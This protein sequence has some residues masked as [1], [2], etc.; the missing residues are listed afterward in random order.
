[1]KHVYIDE[2]GETGRRS[3]YIVFASLATEQHRPVEKAMKKIWR[4][5][6]ALHSH[7]ELHAYTADEATRRRVL[8][9]INGL[10]VAIDFLVIDKLQQTEPL[11]IVYYREL[12]RLVQ[13]HHDAH[14]VI[15]DQKDTIKKRNKLIEQLGL[16][17]V[18]SRVSFARSHDV[19]GLQAVDFVAW[20]IGRSMEFD[21]DTFARLLD[22]T[23]R[24]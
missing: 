17:N 5:K 22:D 1:M 13:Y 18:F 21:D 10:P 14:I 19:R 4:V 15:V 20:A 8:Q 9:T 6:P 11:E 12:A 3:R 16:E 7:G 2:S 24:L 23:H